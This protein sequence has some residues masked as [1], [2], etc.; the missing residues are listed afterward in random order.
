V[1]TIE[2]LKSHPQTY[3]QIPQ[4]Q[5]FL[6]IKIIHSGDPDESIPRSNAREPT[7][8]PP[9][10]TDPS[11]VRSPSSPPLQPCTPSRR[12]HAQESGKIADRTARRRGKID[13]EGSVG[14]SKNRAAERRPKNKVSPRMGDLHAPTDCVSGRCDFFRA[15]YLGEFRRGS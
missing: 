5:H 14:G 11:T 12:T 6:T 1:I 2:P 4:P 7:P 13:R 10:S 15:G 3:R 8:I 9:P